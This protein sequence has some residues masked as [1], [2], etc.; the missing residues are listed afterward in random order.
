[1]YTQTKHVCS[2]VALSSSFFFLQLP[3]PLCVRIEWKIEIKLTKKVNSN[4]INHQNRSFCVALDEEGRR[5]REWNNEI[6]IDP[7]ENLSICKIRFWPMRTQIRRQSMAERA[8]T[9]QRIPISH[10]MLHMWDIYMHISV[11]EIMSELYLLE[12]YHFLVVVVV[13]MFCLAHKRIYDVCVCVC[14]CGQ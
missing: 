12:V 2:L 6:K 4:Y 8:D 9:T 14:V 13:L 11:V 3:L 1:M 5:G 7:A 10:F